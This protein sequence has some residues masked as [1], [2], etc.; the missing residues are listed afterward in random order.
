MTPAMVMSVTTVAGDTHEP[1]TQ[2]ALLRRPPYL[3][4][5]MTMYKLMMTTPSNTTPVVVAAWHPSVQHVDKDTAKAV[6][7]YYARHWPSNKYWV[8]PYV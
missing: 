8:T 1:P 7:Q 4:C 5:T 6:C 3:H 2:G